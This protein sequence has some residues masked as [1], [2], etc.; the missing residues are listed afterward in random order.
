MMVGSVTN[1]FLSH[2]ITSVRSAQEDIKVVT[3]MLINLA[4]EL[5]KGDRD[6]MVLFNNFGKQLVD[7]RVGPT[8]RFNSELSVIDMISYK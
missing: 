1:S 4:M 2:N 3:V 8:G 7:H 6:M 5:D